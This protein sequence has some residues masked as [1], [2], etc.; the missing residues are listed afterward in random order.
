MSNLLHRSFFLCLYSFLLLFF[1][2]PEERKNKSITSLADQ[3]LSSSARFQGHATP[4]AGCFEQRFPIDSPPGSAC[5]LCLGLQLLLPELHTH[6]A[7]TS[8]KHHAPG[9]MLPTSKLPLTLCRWFGLNHPCGAGRE[10]NQGSPS[11]LS[12]WQEGQAAS[13]EPGGPGE[14]TGRAIY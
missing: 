7:E 14:A 2:C 6:T 9:D 13:S 8:H 1:W 4:C 3:C 12:P 11:A 10:G 5:H